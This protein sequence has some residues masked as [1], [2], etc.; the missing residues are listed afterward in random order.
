VAGLFTRTNS[1]VSLLSN[2][3]LPKKTKNEPD[4][5]ILTGTSTKPTKPVKTF[6]NINLFQFTKINS[7]VLFHQISC[8]YNMT[9]QLL[10]PSFLF[11]FLLLSM[12]TID[13]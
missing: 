8:K 1:E 9:S 12:N 2:F 10:N 7:S 13:N 6:G 4:R 11:F 5:R 3:S